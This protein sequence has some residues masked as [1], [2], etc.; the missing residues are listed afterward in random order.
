MKTQFEN[1][2]YDPNS[3][4]PVCGGELSDK[5][6]EKYGKMQRKCFLCGNTFYQNQEK[7]TET[8]GN[9]I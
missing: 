8:Y 3:K 7:E 5:V 9:K 2:P 1:I 4:C 6:V